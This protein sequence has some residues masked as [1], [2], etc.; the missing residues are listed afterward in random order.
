MDYFDFPKE[1]KDILFSFPLNKLAELKSNSET[2]SHSSSQTDSQVTQ[3]AMEQTCDTSSHPSDSPL[4][5]LEV[6]TTSDPLGDTDV[7][8]QT[9]TD[10]VVAGEKLCVGK[11]NSLDTNGNNT[12]QPKDEESKV[13]VESVENEMEEK[14]QDVAEDQSAQCTASDVGAEK[15]RR[16][17]PQKSE[18]RF[19][20]VILF[21]KYKICV[22]S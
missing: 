10:D 5:D 2:L 6:K 9:K 14:E 8:V 13:V 20:L 21:F 18:V 15:K 22:M 16:K 1:Y 17:H 3:S 12:G 4:T 11:N 7:T 19:E